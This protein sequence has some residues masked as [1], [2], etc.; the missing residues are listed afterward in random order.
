MSAWIAQHLAALRDALRRL[1]AAP[2]NTALS[3]LVIGIALTLPSAGW[4]ALEN[5]RMVAGGSSNSQQI[6]IFL[7]LDAGKRDVGEIETRLRAAGAG[8]WHFVAREDALKRLQATEG[9][10]EIVASL[11]R[12]PLPDAFIVEPGDLRPEALEALAKT[13]ADWPKVAHVQLDSAWIKRF[14]AFLRIARLAV[15]ML[16]G[17]FAA[18][19]VAVTFNTI[20]LQI[21]AQAAEIEV[22]RLIGATDAFI[23]RPFQYFG[24]LEG[25]LGGLLAAA[26]VAVGQHLLAAP[27][28]ELAALYGGSFALRGL[29]LGETALLAAA[30]AALGWLGAQISVAIHLRRIG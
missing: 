3:L 11:P 19:L 7:T 10:A 29:S 22:A 26:L 20:R 4:V 1:A 27:V 25:A 30:G 2:L 13:F 28:G 17:L 16:A 12:N 6:S 5:L 14:D 21:L 23:R 8:S 24:A 9:M 15:T 18:A